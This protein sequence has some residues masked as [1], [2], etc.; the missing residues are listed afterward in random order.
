MFE[1]RSTLVSETVAPDALNKPPPPPPG[2]P[3]AELPF[4]ALALLPVITELWTAS[5]PAL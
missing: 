2:V 3:P 4:V 1:R 5:V